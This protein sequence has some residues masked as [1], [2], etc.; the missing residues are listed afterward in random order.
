MPP[1][2]P[3]VE[4]ARARQLE[5]GGRAEE[6]ARAFMAAGDTAEALRVLRGLRPPE[7]A[8]RLLLEAGFVF[9]AAQ[10]HL[11]AGDAAAGLEK[12]LRVSPKDA[13]Y[14]EAARLAVGLASDLD[15]LSVRFEHFI[16]NFISS[17]PQS[18]DDL[19]AFVRLGEIYVRHRMPENAE[20]VFA[21]VV[22][23][24]P[25]YGGVSALL[26]SLRRPVA[27]PHA[28]LATHLAGPDAA[29]RR[30]SPRPPRPTPPAA[31]G[32]TPPPGPAPFKPTRRI[33]G[34]TPPPIDVWRDSFATGAVIANRYRIEGEIGRGGMAT[35][36]RAHDLELAE[37][38]AL[39][40]FRPV[41]KDVEGIARFR[42]EL[43]LSRRLVHPN[44]T[45]V[46]DLGIHQGHRYIS[47][48]LLI[49]HSV[50]E[51]NEKPWPFSKAVDC[52]IQVCRGLETAHAQG[53][54]HRDVKPGNLFLTRERVAKVMDFGIARERS[55]PGVTQVGMIV[56]TPEYMA[57]EQIRGEPATEKSD[58]YALGAVAYEM[59]TGRKVFVHDSLFPLLHMHLTAAPVPLGQL[60]P[61]L[62]S[63]LEA[64]ILRL[65]EKDPARRHPDAG[66][67]ASALAAVSLP[68]EG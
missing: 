41:G 60:C 3:A 54:I 27:A 49:G 35:V 57:P 33:E 13:R 39:K 66:A 4:L 6:A 62:P 9:E 24:S 15:V 31:A 61:G 44:I 34:A 22:A 63:E 53:V 36:Y 12:L 5:R 40:L 51:L 48:E 58:L 20:E 42:Q 32:A 55:A 68:P 56:G 10:W 11:D 1:R 2:D 7:A 46:Y 50:E 43:K 18:D 29:G 45:R 8:A 26:A 30:P 21:K 59:F 67:L 25:D 64:V 14:R 23:R 28:G 38:V 52:L 17:G 65:L 19:P 37:D 47:M 16:G